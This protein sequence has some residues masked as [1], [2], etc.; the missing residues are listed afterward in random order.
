MT[1]IVDIRDGQF[2]VVFPYSPELVAAIKALPRRQWSPETKSWLVPIAS[3]AALEAFTAAHGF[4]WT[5]EALNVDPA[6]M[7][8]IRG[9][10]TVKGKTATIRFAYNPDAVVEIREIAGR[11]WNGDLKVWTAPTTSIRQIMSFAVLFGLEHTDLDALPDADPVTE[12]EVAFKKGFFHIRFPYD[13]DLQQQVQDLPTAKYHRGSESWRVAETAS[14][15]VAEFIR[16]ANGIVDDSAQTLIDAALHD[17]E[18][19]AASRAED[20]VFECPTLNGVL[21]PFQRAGVVYA[22]EA[23]GYVLVGGIWQPARDMAPV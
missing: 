18:R 12:P 1:G 19:V 17:L 21:M 11:R 3:R 23:L 4:T 5:P 13:R 15:D 9:A 16:N 10:V 14:I 20:A 7:P 8:A 6:T 2:D 22:L